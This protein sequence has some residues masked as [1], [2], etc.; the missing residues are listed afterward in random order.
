VPSRLSSNEVKYFKQRLDEI[1]ACSRDGMAIV[2]HRSD[3]VR[4]PAS[5]WLTYSQ[6]KV[7]TRRGR[8]WNELQN[9]KG[10]QAWIVQTDDWSPRKPKSALEMLAEVMDDDAQDA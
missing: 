2:F 4:N 3:T 7:K 5:P 9:L 8:K 1:A 6:G 10:W